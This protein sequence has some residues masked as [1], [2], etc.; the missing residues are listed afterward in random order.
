MVV[1]DRP[2]EVQLESTLY[3]RDVRLL[4]IGLKTLLSSA[5]SGGRGIIVRST[6]SWD[7][8]G[9]MQTACF[10]QH[11]RDCFHCP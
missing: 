1:D 5:W 9:D 7:N 6:Q 10:P 3:S 4:H 11:H 2:V 8:A